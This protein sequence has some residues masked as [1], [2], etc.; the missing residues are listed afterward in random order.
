MGDE[1]TTTTERDT[2]EREKRKEARKQKLVEER[3]MD[4]IAVII[5]KIRRSARST[6]LLIYSSLSH[7]STKKKLKF[8]DE[9]HHHLQYANHRAVP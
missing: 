2:A 6:A 7:W 3:R 1:E 9:I 8:C 4:S 5:L